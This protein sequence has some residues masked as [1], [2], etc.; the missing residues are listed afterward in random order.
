MIGEALY[1][2]PLS[3]PLMNKVR[4]SGEVLEILNLMTARLLLN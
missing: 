3:I 4:S 1:S 2:L